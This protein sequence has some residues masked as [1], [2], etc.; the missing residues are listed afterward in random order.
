MAHR[1]RMI[2]AFL[3]WYRQ[4]VHVAAL[5]VLRGNGGAMRGVDLAIALGESPHGLAGLLEGAPTIRKT[6]RPGEGGRDVTWF[7]I[8]EPTEDRGTVD[9]TARR[10]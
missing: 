3:V 5:T 10:A 8:T 9:R 6:R 4:E 7:E 1:S 2:T